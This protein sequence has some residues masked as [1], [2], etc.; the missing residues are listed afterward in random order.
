MTK[1]VSKVE[2][3]GVFDNVYCIDTGE[4]ERMNDGYAKVHP[5]D[6]KVTLV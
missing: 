4:T 5:V 2:S 3:Y 1:L 6:I